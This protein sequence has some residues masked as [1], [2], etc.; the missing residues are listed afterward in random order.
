MD[1]GKDQA[2]ALI[3]Y[4][5]ASY[6]ARLPL[7]YGLG[8][9]RRSWRY[10]SIGD[11][12]R[13][14]WAVSLSTGVLSVLALG[15]RPV[16]APHN[17]AL[18]LSLSL[19]DGLLITFV[20][21]GL[22][23]GVRGLYDWRHHHKRARVGRRTLI[24]GAGE[25]GTLVAR[26]MRAAPQ[27][28]LDPV[29]F[30]DDDPI[31]V[32]TFIQGLPVLGNCAQIPSV[33][34]NQ[35][36]EQ[37]VVALPSAPLPRQ[38]EI[39]AQCKA[40]GVATYSLP[41]IYE[42]L[43]GHKTVRPYPEADTQ[44]LLHRPS[45]EIDEREAAAFLTSATVLV[46]GAGGSIGSELCRQI[47]RSKPAEI[48]LLGHGENSIF[49]INLNLRI[50][51][52]DVATRPVIVDVRDQAGIDEVVGRYRPDVIFHAA[53]HKHV[54]LMEQAVAEALANN[55]LGTRNVL[56]AAVKHDVSRFVL[57]STDKAVNPS[58]VMGATK[59]LAERL[60]RAT[61]ERVGKPYAAVRFGNVL[62]SR[63]SVIPIFQR[64]IAAG[65][66]VTVTH[67]DMRRYFMT[68]P[69]AAQLVLA[70]GGM[71]RG[72]EVFVLDMGQPVHIVDL[73]VDLI[74]QCGLTPGRD[75]EVTYTGIRPGEKLDEELFMAQED[76]KRT[77]CE[78]VLVGT[79][80][81][82]VPLEPLERLILDLYDLALN[83]KG[84]DANQEMRAL[85]LDICKHTERYVPVID[86]QT[87]PDLPGP[88]L[89]EPVRRALPEPN[90]NRAL[91][92]VGKL[93]W[94]TRAAFP[95]NGQA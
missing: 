20:V 80:A 6:L 82:R 37:I 13:V 62:G 41:G 92:Q 84:A 74:K 53:A 47:A 72:G 54:P 8:L 61:A 56:Q 14:L 91:I 51:Y 36:I 38:N 48:V 44:Q 17:L 71:A 21:G 49:E 5:A 67:P 78:R 29:A 93:T 23:V 19:L 68:I 57:I 77:A 45:I 30:V 58:N 87:K 43:A 11:L 22:R 75:I 65:G 66:P 42:L 86:L 60:V 9:Y 2:W 59:H 12:M 32:D 50:N 34:A 70:A 89:Q 94:S 81:N 7:F 52:P 28:G 4:V 1:W 79:S 73:A 69:E 90:A 3:L 83:Q 35:R 31:K 16:L 76:C 10:A 18:P 39:V 95:A 40:T 33:V 25:A 15:T 46:T 27:L 63:G 55:V 24:V 26:E 64:Q 85:L 88:G